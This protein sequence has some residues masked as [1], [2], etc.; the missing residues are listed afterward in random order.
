ML[1]NNA[2]TGI[3]LS[4]L[5]KTTGWRNNCGLNCISHFIYDKLQS[6][7]LQH[8]FTDHP[9]YIALLE[10]FQSYYQLSERPSWNDIR[11]LLS[12]YPH[13]TDHEAILAPV[14]RQHLGK[15]LL[16][17]N[18]NVWNT[19]AAG[20]I[21]E[22]LT[23]GE[24]RDIAEPLIQPNLAPFLAEH[25]RQ[26]DRRLRAAQNKA[27][28]VKEIILARNRLAQNKPPKEPS[29]ANIQSFV[30]FHRR[31]TLEDEFQTEARAYWFSQGMRLYADY[32]ADL[33]N[34]VMVSADQLC[35]LGKELEIGVEVYTPDSI[36]R[37]TND[38]QL[39]R[40][41]HG[42]Q[43]LPEI[44]H[45]WTLKVH[46]SGVH[47]EYEEPSR[48]PEKVDA[49]NYFY[50]TEF[51]A[52]D[53]RLGAMKTYGGDEDS[54]DEELLQAIV[55]SQLTDV[56]EAKTHTTLTN[57]PDVLSVSITQ[58][59]PVAV[60]PAPEKVTPTKTNI[61]PSAQAASAENSEFRPLAILRNFVA[62][63]RAQ[64][65]EYR[66]HKL[67]HQADDSMGRLLKKLENAVKKG[68]L[69]NIEKQV[70]FEFYFNALEEEFK[71]GPNQTLDLR[72][73]ECLVKEVK[74]SDAIA[75]KH[76]IL[77]EGKPG[78]ELRADR[79]RARSEQEET[80]PFKKPRR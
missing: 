47:W 14:L 16:K 11:E 35:L 5:C 25:K 56:K 60:T 9:A 40:A 73:I 74:R 55:N 71:K 26:F 63:I 37:A 80:R 43:N 18:E 53:P 8:A 58:P 69:N 52:D 78:F 61:E 32:I 4:L 57:I 44:E 39:A 6:N 13:A 62:N 41:T 64:R 77:E 27:P 31:N 72:K 76:F 45:L 22:Y 1:S 70:I 48:D 59:K 12:Q 54:V 2:G 75:L 21:S 23:T 67:H 42:A 50:P 15:I 17:N 66:Y 46:N 30:E 36:E 79:K 28:T 38:P 19:E 24:I 29:E 33:D 68:T 51:Y 20:A 3:D 65:L 10:T 49:H 7:E 34:A